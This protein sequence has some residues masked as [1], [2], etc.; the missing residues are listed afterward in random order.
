MNEPE[1]EISPSEETDE[2]ELRLDPLERGIEPPE[3]WSEA[4]R[5]GMTPAE[6][7]AGEPLDAKLRQEQREV[8]PEDLHDAG[9]LG[10]DEVIQ[11]RIEALGQL[12]ETQWDNADR[13]GGS[14]AESMREPGKQ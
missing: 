7:R 14:V 5:Y 13:A 11:G 12:P 10:D 8:G 3:R 2:D 9:Q 4:N 1:Y 6:Q